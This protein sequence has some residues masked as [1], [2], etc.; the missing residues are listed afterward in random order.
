MNGVET[1]FER[2][3]ALAQPGGRA[4]WAESFAPVLTEL[5]VGLRS[6][7]PQEIARRAGVLWQPEGSAFLL[8]YLDR[9]YRLAWP[10]LIAVEMESGEPCAAELQ[11]LFLYY[12]ARATG[13]PPQERWVAFRELPDG[14]FYHK[15]FQGYTGDLLARA[16]GNDTEGLRRAAGALGG[17]PLDVGDASFRFWGLPRIPLALVY[18]QGDEEFAPRAQI[19]F[20]PVAGDY[21]PIDGSAALGSRLVR[22]LLAQGKGGSA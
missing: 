16:L 4:D 14:G 1:L 9:S 8:R 19:L 20:D 2:N 11:A 6:R 18:W 21:L 3:P 10:G 15:A 13:A 7:T 12:L 5:R 17:Q 22:R